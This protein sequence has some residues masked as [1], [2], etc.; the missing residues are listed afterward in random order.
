MVAGLALGWGAMTALVEVSRPHPVNVWSFLLAFVLV[1]LLLFLFTAAGAAALAR[2]RAAPR[3]PARSTSCSARW[4][5][6]LAGRAFR[7]GERLE[8]WRALGHRLRARRH[9][10][11]QVEPWQL[12]A[13]GQAFGVAF[14]VAAALA[15]LRLVVFTDV[16]FSWSTT[17]GAL[18]PA[19]FHAIVSRL[20]W[21][22][23][24]AFPDAVPARQVVEA[25]RYWH[26]EGRY[27]GTAVG[28][29]L[30]PELRGAWW[31]FLLAALLTYGLLPR[32]A[33]LLLAGWR[34]RGELA[35]LPPGDAETSAVLRRLG[36]RRR[37]ERAGPP[38]RRRRAPRAGRLGGGPLARGGARRR[39]GG[40]DRGAARPA[41]R[42]GAAG[43]RAGLGRGRAAGAPLRRRGGGRAPRRWRSWPRPTSRPTRRRSA[44]CGEARAVLGRTAPML[45][46]LGEPEGETLGAP[47]AGPARH[48][49]HPPGPARG[50]LP[51]RRGRSGTPPRRRAP[52]PSPPTDPSPPGAAP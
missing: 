2:A 51:G 19:G 10:Y 35:A 15:L 50:R 9:L 39:R 1:Q 49:A 5:Q 7:D 38:P 17:L 41:R 34:R 27:D 44:S 8:E 33:M 3:P 36:A 23:G 32:V 21:P 29:A 40:G 37:G 20:A 26:L 16:A 4:S 12:L 6:R 52:G 47:G 28:L 14:N 42:A 48:L 24:W 22:W 31:P 45:V 13:L 11:G 43:R 30:H 46:L 25:T 18:D